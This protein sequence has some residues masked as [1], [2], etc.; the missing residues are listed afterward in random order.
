VGT[1]EVR[2]DPA[3]DRFADVLLRRDDDGEDDE[4]CGRVE[5]R[6]AVDEVVVMLDDETGK[7]PD[8]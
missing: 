4:D 1:G 7:T 8:H 3:V 5:V 2:R 6:H